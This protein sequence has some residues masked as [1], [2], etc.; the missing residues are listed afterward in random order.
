MSR[1]G[2][3]VVI[4][5]A[6]EGDT[7]LS[8]GRDGASAFGPT[9]DDVAA[10]SADAIR[11][12]CSSDA[13][14]VVRALSSCCLANEGDTNLGLGRDGASAFGPTAVDAATLSAGA[15]PVASSSDVGPVVSGLSLCCL[16]HEGHHEPQLRSRRRQCL[17][18]DLRR[19]RHALS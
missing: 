3:L 18:A 10:L 7:N 14:L 12:P 17:W 5:L 15:T 8:F 9:S 13:G 19:R 4:F 6:S 1:R 16:S 11:V 2:R